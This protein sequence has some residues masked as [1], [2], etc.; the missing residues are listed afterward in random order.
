MLF[1]ITALTTGVIEKT[2]PCETDEQS[3]KNAPVSA[4]TSRN[5]FE[6]F[7]DATF[8]PETQN[9][10]QLEVNVNSNN[11][12][13]K[14]ASV[15]TADPTG[16]T[17]FQVGQ[18]EICN[19]VAVSKDGVSSESKC[20]EDPQSCCITEERA[21]TT[22]SVSESHAL[23][24]ISEANRRIEEQDLETLLREARKEASVSWLSLTSVSALRNPKVIAIRIH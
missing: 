19:S 15:N 7:D 6:I 4:M 13:E 1:N 17:N 2:Q 9:Y 3:S 12:E 22:Q 8:S 10:H 21:A 24:G 16:A 20:S 23:L 18:S 5:L 14:M 11:T